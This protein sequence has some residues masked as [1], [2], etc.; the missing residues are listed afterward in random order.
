VNFNIIRDMVIKG[1]SDV[2]N[3]HTEKIK[4][5]RKGS[6]KGGVACVSLITEPEDKIYR[7]SFLKKRRRNDNTSV[8]FGYI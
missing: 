4:R 5:K 7:I 1:E 8:P 2:V 6:A 3:V